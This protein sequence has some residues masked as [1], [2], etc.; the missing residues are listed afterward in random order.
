MANERQRKEASKAESEV[1]RIISLTD[2]IIEDLKLTNV[3]DIKDTDTLED[4]LDRLEG[5]YNQL[6]LQV[7]DFF[8]QHQDYLDAHEDVELEY[9]ES[10]LKQLDRIILLQA[11]GDKRRNELNP[12]KKQAQETLSNKVGATLLEEEEEEEQEEEEKEESNIM[13]SRSVTPPTEPKTTNEAQPSRS[14]PAS[15][16]IKTDTLLDNC[17]NLSK[18]TNMK[19]AGKEYAR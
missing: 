12:P 18:D 13:E 3:Q 15:Q 6:E 1:N 2:A 16:T 14:Q 5:I 9:E 10:L 19:Q 7:E 4:Y 11:A 8:D 17:I